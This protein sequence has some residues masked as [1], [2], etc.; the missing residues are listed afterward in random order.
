MR[1]SVTSYNGLHTAWA[2][3]WFDATAKAEEFASQGGRLPATIRDE[4][5]SRWTKWAGEHTQL[6]EMS[7]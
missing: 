1:Y 3:C 2:D 5:G 7:A 4:Q 6:Q